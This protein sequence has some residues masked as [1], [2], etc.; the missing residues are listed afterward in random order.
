M[1]SVAT[2]R[3]TSTVFHEV[4]VEVEEEEEVAEGLLPCKGREGA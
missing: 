1:L 3:S 4:E 2:L